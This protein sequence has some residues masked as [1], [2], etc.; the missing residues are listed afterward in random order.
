MQNDT[1]AKI[2]SFLK[3]HKNTRRE[4]TQDSTTTFLQL[5]T[6][7]NPLK[8]FFSFEKSRIVPENIKSLLCSQNLSFLVKIEESFDKN[9]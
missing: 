8:I 9:K 2:S 4:N 3:W 5:E 1:I 7:K 6:T